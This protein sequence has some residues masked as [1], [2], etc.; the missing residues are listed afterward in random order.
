MNWKSLVCLIS[1]AAIWVSTPSLYA[2]FPNQR[3]PNRQ[4]PVQ[5]P[6]FPLPNTQFPLQNPQ[7]PII[8]IQQPVVPGGIQNPQQ[9]I[10]VQQPV[11]MPFNPQGTRNNVAST[12]E[13]ALEKQFAAE[14]TNIDVRFTRRGLLIEVDGKNSV[15]FN[16]IDTAIRRI[17]QL[18]RTRVTVIPRNLGELV[19]TKILQIY[20]RYVSNVEAKVDLQNRRALVSLDLNY[21]RL[22]QAVERT[23]STLPELRGYRVTTNINVRRR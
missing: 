10:I 7:R 3:I 20:T 2:Q 12:L 17:P 16:K 6:Q 11:I 14:V 1:L 21:G 23:V 18:A 13:R 4:F 5:N 15:V 19:E 8:I 9:P 22:R